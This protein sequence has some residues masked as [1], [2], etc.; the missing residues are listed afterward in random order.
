MV[1]TDSEEQV[2]YT[3]VTTVFNLILT[4]VSVKAN[5]LN[6]LVWKMYISVQ[7]QRCMDNL[8]IYM[9]DVKGSG[10]SLT[11][12]TFSSKRLKDSYDKR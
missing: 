11:E 1:F 10:K 6:L 3:Q 5:R 7:H 9:C 2:I 8:L 12:E 4:T